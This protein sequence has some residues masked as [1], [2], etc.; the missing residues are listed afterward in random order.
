MLLARIVSRS[1]A[2]PLVASSARTIV[3]PLALRRSKV[4]S[5]GAVYPYP[6]PFKAI[7]ARLIGLTLAQSSCEVSEERAQLGVGLLR[8]LLGEVVAAVERPTAHFLGPPA[9]D[10]QDVVV[11]LKESLAAPQGEHRARYAPAR[12]AVGLVVLVVEGGRGPIVLA[13]SV[14]GLWVAE[15]AHV[16]LHRF[17]VENLAA[18]PEE[19]LLRIGGEQALG[20]V[21]WLGQEEP[22]PVAEAERHVGP[23]EGLPRR[24]DVQDRELRHDPGMVEGQAVA[25][26][27]AAV[28][29]AEGEALEAEVAHHLDLI[30]CHRP[31]RVGLVIG[32]GLG[33][34]GVT[35]SA[36]VGGDHREVFGEARGDEVPHGVRLGAAV[37]QQQRRP[38]AAVTD[39]DRRLG[40]V[41][42]GKPKTFEHGDRSLSSLVGYS[43]SLS[44]LRITSVT[45]C[46]WEIMTT[47]EASTSVI[48]APARSAMELTT[49]APAALSP[50]A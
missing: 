24:H 38:T 17:R 7:L 45:S 39:P 6:G 10:V 44:A 43:T 31:L 40:G 33:L 4:L 9:P 49:S 11:L 48:L 42:R 13:R 14:D 8:S 27:P 18:A 21:E 16:L 3:P 46:G 30:E 15:A 20:Q 29:A 36:Q 41:D 26:A 37:E 34:G 23:A 28:V 19:G 1:T 2:P 12:P 25:E 50:V 47:W 35:V 32:G 22:V 5:P